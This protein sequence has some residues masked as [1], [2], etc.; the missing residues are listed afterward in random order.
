MLS[1]TTYHYV[2][3][4]RFKSVLRHFDHGSIYLLI[5]A[6]FSPVTLIMLRNVGVWGWTIFTLV[7]FSAVVG[8]ILS[9]GTLKANNHLKTASYVLMGL[10]IFIAIKPLIQ[11]AVAENCV[12]VLYWLAAGGAFYIVGAV[13]YALAKKEFIHAVFHL[14]VLFG[15]ICHIISAYLIPL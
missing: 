4:P 8:I 6:S 2:T 13:F 15:L 3:N 1:S 11:V 14:F 7:W 10:L 5:A 12:A 9:F